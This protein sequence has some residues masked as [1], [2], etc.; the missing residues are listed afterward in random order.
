[1]IS[2]QH[3]VELSPIHRYKDS[4]FWRFERYV[5]GV[6]AQSSHQGTPRCMI[7]HSQHASHIRTDPR[8]AEV[9]QNAILEDLGCNVEGRTVKPVFFDSLIVP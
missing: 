2:L 7:S 4:R 5:F 3:D 9:L 6:V 1:M 8:L